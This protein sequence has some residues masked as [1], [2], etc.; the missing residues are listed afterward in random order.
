MNFKAK[1]NKSIE[2]LGYIIMYF[3]FTTV[4]YFILRF[5]NKLPETWNYFY[6]AIITLFIV[7]IGRLIRLLLK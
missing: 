5:F 6:I 1:K 2:W 4:L 3:I 7:L